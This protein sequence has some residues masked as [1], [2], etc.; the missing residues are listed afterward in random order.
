MKCNRCGQFIAD[1]VST[2]PYCGNNIKKVVKNKYIQG[3]E[4]AKTGSVVSNK[5]FIKLQRLEPKKTEIDRKNFVN[6]ID[7]QE[8]KA[9][10][11]Q[12]NPRFINIFSSGDNS[13][14]TGAN[15]S[16][17][18]YINNRVVTLDKNT[19]N[20]N[21]FFTN[22]EVIP[23]K[24]RK[25]KR[26][27]LGYAF[28][29]LLILGAGLFILLKDGNSTAYYFGEK[30]GKDGDGN[31]TVVIDDEMLQYEGV[32]KS[33][34]TGIV[35]SNEET[36]IVFDYQY[37]E[38]LIFNNENDVRRLI[39]SDSNKQK[40]NCLPNVIKIE[41]EII[42]NYGI[43]AVNFCEMPV[44]MAEELKDVISYIYVNF[45]T[46][47]DYLTNM[48]IA[49]VGA[50]T[51]IAAF[52]PVFTFGTSRTSTGYPVA[53]KTQIILNAK[54]FLNIDRLTNS[55]EYGVKSGYFPR[56]ASKSSAVAHE[57]GHYLS[58]VALLNHYNTSR[59]NFV[60]ASQSELLYDVY[61]DLNNGNYSLQILKEAY[62]R[63]RSEM[64]EKDCTIRCQNPVILSKGPH[65]GLS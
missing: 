64:T 11:E 30:N 21:K 50:N 52:M 2:C 15:K 47:R 55:V 54:Y 23:A 12:N 20:H 10:N 36:S 5:S 19:N 3:G 49:N 4:T 43:V 65:R 39:A 56:G 22:V 46:A 44:Q 48:T 24:N 59:L 57:F 25:T 34:Q 7:Y 35:T 42:N 32:S 27:N 58:Y 8:A 26:F 63:Y 60:R 53:I 16:K 14:D 45:P 33:G 62:N 18:K 28:L 31:N 6:Y 1:N 13:S 29:F 41:N 40:G 38:Q 37:F 9:K 17:A 51:Y 61:D